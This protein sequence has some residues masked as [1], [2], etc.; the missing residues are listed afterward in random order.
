MLITTATR[1]TTIAKTMIAVAIMIVPIS[2][3]PPVMVSVTVSVIPFVTVFVSVIVVA[4][5]TV[6]VIVIP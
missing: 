3:T 5:P 6:L 1:P 4:T 2:D